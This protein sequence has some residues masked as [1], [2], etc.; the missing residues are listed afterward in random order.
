MGG[1]T[2]A[3]QTAGP[4]LAFEATVRET[5]CWHDGSFARQA[6]NAAARPAPSLRWEMKG[7]WRLG[8]LVLLHVG[9]AYF[10]GL[11]RRPFA[12]RSCNQTD[13]S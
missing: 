5:E 12:S 4:M 1:T 10:P 6:G 7:F 8:D 11:S 13:G 3:D 9:L 2:F